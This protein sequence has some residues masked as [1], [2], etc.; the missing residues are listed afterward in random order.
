[1]R[2]LVALAASLALVATG[3]TTAAAPAEA[4]TSDRYAGSDRYATSVTIS[5]NTDAGAIVFLA[6]GQKFPDALS[7]GPVVA[8]ERGHLLLTKPNELPS[9]VA[10]RIAEIAPSEVVVVGSEASVS[11]GVAASAAAISGATLTRIGGANRVETSLMLM[12]R[13]LETGPV[14]TVWVASGFN[15]PDA[16]VAASVAGRER[17]AVVLDHHGTSAAAARSWLE[18]VAPYVGGR[19]VN[20]AGGAPSV[21]AAD[22]TGIRSSGAR[23][24]TRYAGDSRYTTARAINDAFAQYPTEPTMLLATGKNFPDALAGAVHAAIRG[25]PMY[26]TP[27]ACNAQIVSMLSAEATE[28]GIS[29]VIG[30]GSGATVSDHALSLQPCPRTLPELIGDEY[31][32]FSARTFS[33]TGDR[34]I[35]LGMGIA[36]GQIRATMPADDINQIT[37]LDAGR[38]MVDLP[39]SFWGSYSGTSLLA[40]YSEDSPA[41]YLEVKSRGSW[42]IEVRD[43]TSAPVLSSSASG[44]TDTVYLYGGSARTIEG[45]H[46]GEGLFEVRE[47]YGDGWM[48]WPISNCCD[49]YT[50]AGS[51]HAGPSVIAVTAEAPWSV[52]LR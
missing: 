28:R 52:T 46:R 21:S 4:F 30:L 23:S 5:R 1:M 9:I 31:G 26:L 17:A 43:L 41:R 33:G 24:V 40:T 48:G 35:D 3:L 19:D 10:Q 20:I 11:A 50:G 8:A 47:L 29:Q 38:D 36:Y 18:A 42:T 13:L 2:A 25:I 7:A 32:R 45:S 44:T 27:D 34:V 49:A 51:V 37:A 14:E 39:L 22:E 16:L 6:N 12:D 15:F